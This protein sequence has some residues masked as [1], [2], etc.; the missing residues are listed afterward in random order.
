MAKLTNK[1]A[2]GTSFHGTV[3]NT[4]V[5]TLEKILGGITY[6][7]NSGDKV[8]FEWVCETK[9]GEIFTIYDWKEY[10]PIG[11]DE[12]IEFHIGGNNETITEKAL[13]EL[14]AS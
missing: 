11:Y 2:S 10:R 9:D 5:S 7:Y 8:N 6:E 3:I 13:N 1:S 14:L 12:V 4:T